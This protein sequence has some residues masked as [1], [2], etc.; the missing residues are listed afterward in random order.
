MKPNNPRISIIIPVLN[1][2]TSIAK[3][4]RYLKSNSSSENIKEIIVVDGGSSDNTA[5]IAFNEQVSVLHSKKGRAKQ[6]NFGAQNAT[7]EILYFL[8]V[9]TLPPKNFDQS[10]IDAVLLQNDVGCFQMKFDSKSRF[11]AF[12]AWF[13][14]I[15]IK[16]CRGGD[17]SLFITKKLFSEAKGFNEDYIVFEDNEFIN[18]IYTMTNFT[19]L[20]R[21]VKTSA[22]R[23]EERGEVALQYHFGMIHLKNYLGAGPEQLYDYYKRKIVS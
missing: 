6:M 7:G 11:L 3:I 12:F 15:N 19:V 22:R 8:H 16:L 2:A 5:N 23:Y 13:T 21:H 10:I 20:P 18:R 1:E 17:Q 9:D 4:L 14:R